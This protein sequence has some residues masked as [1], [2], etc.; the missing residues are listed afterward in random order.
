MQIINS[1][2]PNSESL[3]TDMQAAVIENSAWRD[4]D[5]VYAERQEAGIVL[6]SFLEPYCDNTA[7]VLGIPAGGI[8]VGLEVAR[9]LGICF[10]M[11]IIRKIPIPGNAEAGFGAVSLEGDIVLNKPLVRQLGLKK[12]DVERLIKPVTDQIAERDLLF[13]AGR[14][15]P[16]LKDKTV[17]LVDDG[18]AS[19]YTMGV[20]AEV[21]RRRKPEKIIVAVP[22][23]PAGTI[24]HLAASADIII[25]P[26]IR[27]SFYFAVASA[28]RQWHDLD[29]DEVLAL[30]RSANTELK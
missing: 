18:L 3:T 22:T 30:L 28:Y 9:R 29:N 11:I 27:N 15:F 14:Q 25:C 13:R 6:A 5:G 16:V 7:I 8:P 23:A 21:V 4:R 10:D 1:L 19:G 26:N 12:E 2:T 17:I 20:A 24:K